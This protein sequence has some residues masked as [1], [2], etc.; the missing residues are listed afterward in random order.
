MEFHNIIKEF[1]I[2]IDNRINI[3]RNDVENL[4]N[5]DVEAKIALAQNVY[6]DLKYHAVKLCE[7]IIS[8]INNENIFQVEKF[9]PLLQSI[10][11]A[12]Y[13]LNK[14][15]I[16]E[17]FKIISVFDAD[18]NTALI[19]GCI[20]SFCDGNADIKSLFK[21]LL[22]T[23]GY[24]NENVD[25]FL[26]ILVE[27]CTFDSRGFEFNHQKEY[28]DDVFKYD[29]GFSPKIDFVISILPTIKGLYIQDSKNNSENKQESENEQEFENIESC[30]KKLEFIKNN[31]DTND[32]FNQIEIF[33]L[34]VKEKLN[35][36]INLNEDE[37][38]YFKIIMGNEFFDP[39][40]TISYDNNIANTIINEF[41]QKYH[42]YQ[43]LNNLKYLEKNIIKYCEYIDKL[44][45]NI[46]GNINKII[47]NQESTIRS[48]S[49][50]RDLISNLD[51]NDK[52]YNK[53]LLLLKNIEKNLIN[54]A[55]YINVIK[56][57]I[58]LNKKKIQEK[59][60]K[61]NINNSINN[62]EQLV[63]NRHNEK[64][65]LKY[66]LDTVFAINKILCQ[67]NKSHKNNQ[68]NK[69]FFEQKIILEKLKQEIRL[70][71][72]ENSSNNIILFNINNRHFPMLILLNFSIIL[73]S[74]IKKF[75]KYI[76][77]T[78]YLN[79]NSDV[80]NQRVIS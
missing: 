43:S 8:Q 36:R 75:D 55:L 49:Y 13:S 51:I 31:T 48:L 50:V 6:E 72:I 73:K 61:N 29:S 39:I 41:Q 45:I 10:K 26:S 24:Q 11:D 15:Q 62:I 5:D 30:L 66:Q 2:K 40:I 3:F 18:Q 58:D 12:K 53:K 64:I 44:D 38:K 4:N 70:D 59:E 16:I 7:V 9:I 69:E 54:S 33:L 60:F 27:N 80:N 68:Q 46:R 22:M 67:I 47:L 65:H 74:M 34:K 25:Q 32:A 21:M 52:E 78:K 28:I 57:Y 14:S 42:Q 79:I 76:N 77:L 35:N 20:M 56:T 23:Y 19:S 37:L 17:R 63:S 1:N 71:I